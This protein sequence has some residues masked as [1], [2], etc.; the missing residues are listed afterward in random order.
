M[1]D[2]YRTP[3]GREFFDRLLP[4]L[5]SALERI[6]DRLECHEMSQSTDPS[7]RGDTKSQEVPPW[8]E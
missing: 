1:L 5:V 6:A 7:Q 3:A 2:F 8:R 4:R